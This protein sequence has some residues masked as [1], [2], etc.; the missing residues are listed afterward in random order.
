[1][2][3]TTI[4]KL[5]RLLRI[6]I[7]KTVYVNFS[8]LPF[9]QAIYIPII[10]TRNVKIYS[11][12]GN[13][14]LEGRAHT[15]MVRFGFLGEDNMYWKNERTLLK[16]DG[17]LILNDKIAFASGVLI[18]V[19]KNATLRIEKNVKISNKV[20]II[21][22]T[23]IHIKKNSRIAWETQIIDTTFHY[24]REKDSG[25]FAPLNSPITIGENNWIGN[26]TSIMK[27]AITPNYCIIASGSLVN[28]PIFVEYSIIAGTPAK[29]VKEGVYRVLDEEEIEIKKA[30]N[31]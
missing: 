18:R 8:K 4:N 31:E 29:L 25:L 28:K 1:M 5:R 17:K 24:I 20:K 22:Y 13:I 11:F 27:G 3:W 26:R 7:L 2:F 21:C 9:R 23:N 14:K 15:A 16:I 12:S 19:E 6:S 30:C 10:I